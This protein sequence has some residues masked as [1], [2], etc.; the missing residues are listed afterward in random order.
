MKINLV[1]ACC[2]S[3][4]MGCVSSA[5]YKEYAQVYPPM[6]ASFISIHKEE[7][8]LDQNDCTNKSA[9]YARILRESGYD[10][11]MLVLSNDDEERGHC[12]TVIL[13]MDDT[14]DE[15]K[16]EDRIE[17]YCPTEGIW[18]IEAVMG[19]EDWLFI[20]F[21]ERFDLSK[22]AFKEYIGD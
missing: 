11:H 19:Y 15:R 5:H 6:F 16:R 4:S 12:V 1:L 9:K 3:L 20:R 8:I 13:Y 7:Y 2:L 21:E 18:G 10:A 14:L 22:E 17:F